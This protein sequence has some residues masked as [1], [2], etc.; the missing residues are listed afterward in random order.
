MRS[1]VETYLRGVHLTFAHYTSHAVDHSDE[2]VRQLSMLLYEDSQ[3]QYS[4]TVDL[5]AVEAYLL[6]LSAYLHDAGMVVSDSEK[7]QVLQ[8]DEWLDFSSKHSAELISDRELKGAAGPEPSADQQLF[9]AGL[10]Q[11]LMLAEFFRRQH[12]SR[13][14]GAINSAL[15]VDTDCLGGDTAAVTTLAA[16]CAG[17]GLGRGDLALDFSYPNRRDIFAEPVQV[18]LLTILLRLGDL[19]DMRF[20]RACP[21]LHSIASPLPASSEVHWSQY[22]RITNRVT[23]PERIEVR[24]ECETAQEHRLL[25][26]WCSWIVDE[27]RA[28]PGLVGGGVRHANW[29]PPMAT[30]GGPDDSIQI[31]RAPGARYRP[32]DWRFQF[33]E[34]EVVL[35]LVQ[36]VHR[37]PLGF[38]RELLQNA[39]DTTRAR[40]CLVAGSSGQFP[41]LLPEADRARFTIDVTLEVDGDAVLSV[42]V[43]DNGLGMTSDI[44]KNYFLQ[45]GRSWYRSDQFQQGFRFAP[46]SRFGIGF[47]SVFAV[48]DEVKV[49]TRWHQDEPDSSLLMQLSGPRSYLL[50][51]DA[52]RAEPGTT[53]SVRLKSKVSVDEVLRYL[54]STC[55][56]NEFEVVVRARRTASEPEEL[57]RLP[58]LDD[59]EMSLVATEL[60]SGLSFRV[61][62]IPLTSPGVFGFV[63]VGVIQRAGQ[64]EDWTHGMAR[65]KSAAIAIDPI[66]DVPQLPRSIVAL[67]GLSSDSRY[68]AVSGGEGLIRWNVD[69]RTPQALDGMGLDR[70]GPMTPVIPVADLEAALDQHLAEVS[71]EAPYR[72]AL[73][74][75]FADVA[76]RWAS[77]LPYLAS[78]TGEEVSFSELFT[79]EDVFIAF[80]PYSLN[81]P[82]APDPGLVSDLLAAFVADTPAA[83]SG[84][85]APGTV[86]LMPYGQRQDVFRRLRAD[87]VYDLDPALY[88]AHFVKR[89]EPDRRRWGSDF[90]S[91]SEGSQTVFVGISGEINV[92]NNTH[93]FI[94]AVLEIP[95]RHAGARDRILEKV[96]RYFAMDSSLAEVTRAAATAVGDQ[97]LAD[98]ASFFEASRTLSTRY[99][100][101]EFFR[102]PTDPLSALA[103][104]PSKAAQPSPE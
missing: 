59:D 55:T 45:I 78:F 94:Q 24:A 21:L 46:S 70:I 28:A 20:D 85:L 36:D 74:R 60:A 39:L 5:N 13:A 54:T 66:G 83:G 17:H 96:L 95:E 65:L 14:G 75:R 81:R 77:D 100:P 72:A 7:L 56:A 19:L 23:S 22:A 33:D 92:L 11:R 104:R 43:K 6:L 1:R 10:E 58:R 90:C 71:R 41:N 48:S 76:P 8:S 99:A 49:T 27:A 82:S 37:E 73:V 98:F 102:L 68:H 86:S 101:T 50:L 51:E 25:L 30:V 29:K 97:R 38:L 40:A 89:R 34:G 53:V 47:L 87:H 12:A 91:F 9:V 16:I 42:E 93:A 3:D 52:E 88:V 80:F 18:R 67:N 62:R 64:P 61:N 79:K 35:R 15:R 26:D 63:D 32:E 4:I 69:I 31:L 2:I 84:L 44:V 57:A 103:K